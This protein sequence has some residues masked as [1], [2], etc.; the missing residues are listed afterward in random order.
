MASNTIKKIDG[1][2]YA[3]ATK[4]ITVSGDGA[5]WYRNVNA[6]FSKSGY[7]CI[8]ILAITVNNYLYGM[9]SYNVA[10]YTTDSSTPLVVGLRASSGV[11]ATT[12][13][14]IFGFTLLYEK[15]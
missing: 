9:V 2:E 3:V 14:V 12:A 1:K 8:G 13:N 15:E 4:Q 10:P 6:D 11:W 7:K 5:T